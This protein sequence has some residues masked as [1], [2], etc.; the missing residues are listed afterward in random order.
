VRGC[1]D[2]GSFQRL[3]FGLSVGGGDSSLVTLGLGVWLGT[4]MPIN[5]WG[6]I[7]Q[8]QK[9]VRGIKPASDEAKARK[10]ALHAWRINFVLSIPMR[11]CM[12]GTT[13]PLSF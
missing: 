13:H 2:R 5:V 6:P 12:A 8:S 10:A 9:K 7:W 4:I 11:T 3:R 1:S